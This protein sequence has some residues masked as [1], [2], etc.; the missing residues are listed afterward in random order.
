LEGMLFGTSKTDPSALVV[1]A[2]LLTLV[3]A[4]AAF[5]PAL[6]AM[7]VEPVRALRYE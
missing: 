2:C 5:L 3:S 7:R 1:T 6:R 4:L